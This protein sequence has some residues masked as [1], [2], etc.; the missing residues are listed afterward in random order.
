V[1]RF[2]SAVAGVHTDGA[3]GRAARGTPAALR[4]GVSSKGHEPTGRGLARAVLLGGLTVAALDGIYALVLWL[5]RGVSAR[6][7]FQGVA[8]G[9]LGREAA[10][11]G[12]TPTA[13]LGLA[14]HLGIATTIVAVYVLA[15]RRVAALVERPYLFGPLYGGAVYFVMNWVVIPLSAIGGGGP[16]AV[17]V[18]T[19]TGLF[20]HLFLI[21][22]PAALFARAAA[23]GAAPFAAPSGA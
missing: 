1:R 11:A 18:V 19:V 10:V 16:R 14:L 9:L 2:N 13:L 17:T 22:L 7:V 12:G 4:A 23:R 21:G 8:A 15:G 6:R 3:A 5:P 20:V